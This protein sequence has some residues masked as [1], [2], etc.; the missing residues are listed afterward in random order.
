M[1]D[2]QQNS[3]KQIIRVAFANYRQAQADLTGYMDYADID[4]DD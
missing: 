4:L 2:Q 3:F 1:F